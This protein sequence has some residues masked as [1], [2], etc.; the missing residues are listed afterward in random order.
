VGGF[1]H[2]LRLE[3]L[4]FPINERCRSGKTTIRM[5]VF[6]IVRLTT[7]KD[8]MRMRQMQL[9][10][11]CLLVSAL[12]PSLARAQAPAGLPVF[13]VTPQDSTIKFFVKS[14]VA[15]EG[16][17]R[18]WDATLTYTSTDYKTGALDVRI[19]ADS[20]NTGSSMKDGK[21]KS[22]DFFNVE[23]DSFITFKSTGVTQ[24]GPTTF[25][26]DGN[27]TI[28]GVTKPEKLILEVTGKGTG[29][30]TISGTMAFDRKDYGMNSSIPFIKIADRVEV[31]VNLK[32][33]RV[34][35][36]PLV[37]NQ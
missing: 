32:V 1:E 16:N 12:F 31:T 13:K 36:P 30:G 14:S 21:L 15:L 10:A 35:G 25:E 20:V 4:A 24:T 27:F 23:Q 37:F 3:I 19:Y 2:Q 34:S 29:E 28:R 5:L 33:K 11:L 22:K 18:K 17:F 8:A 7:R 26:V 9:A 6:R